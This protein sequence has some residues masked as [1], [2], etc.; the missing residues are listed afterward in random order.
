MEEEKLLLELAKLTDVHF[1]SYIDKK[2]E[3]KL[4]DDLSAVEGVIEYFKL[5]AE[6]DM[7]RYFNA[8]TEK[9]RDMIKG[10]YSLANYMV[11]KIMAAKKIRDSKK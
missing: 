5:T 9:E 2:W 8:S 6:M 1:D 10:H 4:L 7:H 11:G 3:A